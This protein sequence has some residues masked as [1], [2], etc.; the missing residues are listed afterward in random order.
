MLEQDSTPDPT[1][2]PRAGECVGGGAAE[3]LRAVRSGFYD[4]FSHSACSE[5]LSHSRA[6][7][8]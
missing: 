5:A 4:L 2:T 1:A 7:L 8:L 3:A 6:S